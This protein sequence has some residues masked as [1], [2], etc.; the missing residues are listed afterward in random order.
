MY[1]CIG[2]SSSGGPGR[3][4]R[5]EG[6]AWDNIQKPTISFQPGGLL[7]ITGVENINMQVQLIRLA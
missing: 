2:S 4:L 7:A 1:F 3:V 6:E 5:I